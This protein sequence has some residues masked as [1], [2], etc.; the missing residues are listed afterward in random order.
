MGLL[1]GLPGW[2]CDT[3]V[4]RPPGRLILGLLLCSNV[5]FGAVLEVLTQF[6]VT[7]TEVLMTTESNKFF[8]MN[9]QVTSIE[10][11]FLPV[12]VGLVNLTSPGT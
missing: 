1:G 3:G 8:E 11:E 4:L 10:M 6:G 5:D 2:G 12:V 7:A 9:N